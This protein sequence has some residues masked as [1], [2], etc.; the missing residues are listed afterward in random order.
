MAPVGV[1]FHALYHTGVHGR[2]WNNNHELSGGWI[3]LV[4]V[5]VVFD[6]GGQG[7]SA[8]PVYYRKR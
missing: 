2:D 7:K 8:Q 5:A 4:I 1:P 6:L 3:V